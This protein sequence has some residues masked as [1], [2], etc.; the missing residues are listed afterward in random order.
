MAPSPAPA[1]T[2]INT[3]TSM[4]TGKL[5]FDATHP[6]SGVTASP[7]AKD[8]TVTNIIKNTTTVTGTLASN[9]APNYTNGRPYAN[10]TFGDAD[11]GILHVELNGVDIQ[12]VNLATFTSGNSLNAQNS[13]VNLSAATSVHF[14]NGNALDLFKYRSGTY[15]ITPASMRSGYNSLLIKHEYATGLFR[16]TNAVTWI[17]DADATLPAYSGESVHN[18][19]MTGSKYLSGVQY[20]TGGTAQY[21]VT[22]DNLYR[23]TY[24]SSAT[25]IAFN[26]SNV[27]LTSQALTAPT[28]YTDQVVIA[29]KT[30]TVNTGIRILN[31]SFTIVTT[32]SKVFPANISSNGVVYNNLLVD[33]VADASTVINEGFDGEGFRMHAGVVLTNT[34]YGSGTAGASAYSWDSTQSLVGANANHNTGLLVANSVLAYPKVSTGGVTNGN[35]SAVTNGPAGNPDYSVA[36]GNRTYIR[37]FY[38]ASARSNFKLNVTATNTSFVPVAT[39][40][41]GNN[42][43]LEILAPNTTV[44]ASGTVVWKDAATNY[45]GVDSDVGCYASTY[46]NVIPTNWGLTIGTKNTSTSGKVIA[47]KITASAAWTGNISNIA[48]T[49]L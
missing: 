6:I 24:N 7:S 25:A 20:H 21:D 1:L 26:G 22:I 14:D 30:A 32:T 5:S 36:T 37:Y 9:V 16:I 34:T 40:P 28:A 11:Q 2:T 23:N 13:G 49:W 15:T 35:F 47:V 29:N 43:T 45:S 4:Y 18:V 48:I 39:G 8:S 19:S 42:L 27:T 3:V 33:S 12:T 46:G 31:S 10:N 38:D 44:N 41:S 17:V